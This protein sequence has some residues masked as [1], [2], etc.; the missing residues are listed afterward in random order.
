MDRT[1]DD[2]VGDSNPDSVVSRSGM[3][4]ADRD[5]EIKLEWKSQ[6]RLD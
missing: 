6:M 5:T 2:D 1:E 3:L 4:V